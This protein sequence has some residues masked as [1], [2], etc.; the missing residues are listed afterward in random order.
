ME[1][2]FECPG[3]VGD[4]YDAVGRPVIQLSTNERRRFAVDQPLGRSV[5]VVDEEHPAV[6]LEA[7]ANERPERLEALRRHIR[8]LEAEE[9]DVVAAVRHPLE[10]VRTHEAGAR[11]AGTGG[12][13][14]KHLGRGVNGRDVPRVP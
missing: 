14:H 5:G 8:Q 10:D 11:V 9:H 7:L 13:N 1:S 2:P 12:G 4:L 3:F 6:R